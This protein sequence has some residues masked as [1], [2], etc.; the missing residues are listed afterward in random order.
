MKENKRES[1]VHEADETASAAFGSEHQCRE[2]REEDRRKA[3]EYYE[4]ER[5]EGGIVSLLFFELSLDVIVLGWAEDRELGLGHTGAAYGGR[6]HLGQNLVQPLE[7]PV[8][9]QLDPAG[10]ARHCLP[11]V[12]CSP[13]FDKTHANGA[14]PGQLINSLEP[15][16]HRLSQQCCKLL[17]VEDLQVTAWGD[18]TDCCRMPAIP[19]ITV[20]ALNKDGAIAKTFSKHFPTNIIQPDSSSYMSSGHL[21]GG[22]AVDVGQQAQA[23]S[24]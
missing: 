10:G 17:V 19:L 24:L 18:F 22:V 5:S 23:E 2:D 6:A 1:K 9:M 8:Q 15:L 21:D 4:R 14:H 3:H 11:S 20:R 16:V 7:G 13:A 12:L